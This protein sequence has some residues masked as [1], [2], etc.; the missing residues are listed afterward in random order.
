MN[1]IGLGIEGLIARFIS[2][3]FYFIIIELSWAI[4]KGI[5]FK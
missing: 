4:E 3:F 5:D 1:N 2:H